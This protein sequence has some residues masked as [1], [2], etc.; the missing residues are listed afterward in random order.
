M[1]ALFISLVV[2]LVPFAGPLFGQDR[3]ALVIGNNAYEQAKELYNPKRDAQ[4]IASA[5][6]KAGYDVTTVLDG[7]NR[8]MVRALSRFCSNHKNAES[9]IFYFAGHGMEVEGQNYLIPV[10]AYLEEKAD[11]NLETLAL[12]DVMDQMDDAGM[13]LKIVMLDCCR[14]DP[15]RSVSRS[16]MNTRSMAGGLAEVKQD[17]MAQGTV[18]VFAGEPGRTVPDGTGSNS[19][20][21]TAL[22]EQLSKP[23]LSLMGILTGIAKGIDG[24]QKP[25][26]VF[27]GSAGN[28][29][30]LNDYVIFAG[31]AVAVTTPSPTPTPAPTPPPV[32]ESKPA[33]PVSPPVF[34]SIGSKIAEKSTWTDDSG[35]TLEAE[36]VN[37]D[38]TNVVLKLTNGKSVP[39]PI[40]KLSAED[41]AWIRD[42]TN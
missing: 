33:M 40:S 18:L 17:E 3:V 13:G 15:F 8:D 21:T 28:L 20:F 12:K 42:V 25:W 22:L 4:S 7:G 36:Y 19:P 23:G 6:T 26:F 39:F 37:A 41:Q 29:V 31:Q 10:D 11:L 5:L 35:R 2:F 38:G 32:T 27:D 34:G 9:A 16:W 30:A 24:S 14:D 1:K